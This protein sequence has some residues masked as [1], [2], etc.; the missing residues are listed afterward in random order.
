[1]GQP[2]ACNH[3]QPF[4]D[5]TP[6]I[7]LAHWVYKSIGVSNWDYNTVKPMYQTTPDQVR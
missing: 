1:M 5:S 4:F 7:N 2:S 3:N 6:E